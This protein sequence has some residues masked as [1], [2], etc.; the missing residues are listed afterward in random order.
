MKQ[1]FK[2]PLGIE[3]MPEWEKLLQGKLATET[4]HLENSEI[5]IGTL[6]DTIKTQCELLPPRRGHLRDWSPILNN[7][8]GKLDFNQPICQGNHG[9]ALINTFT[10][11]ESES[12]GKGGIIY[13]PGSRV[14]KNKKIKIP[15][16]FWDKNNFIPV[17]EST[18]RFCPFLQTLHKGK[19]MPLVSFHREQMRRLDEFNFGLESDLIYQNFESI[20]PLLIQLLKNAEQS[21]NP[22]RAFQNIISHFIAKDGSM[23][24]FSLEVNPYC[25][26]DDL[27]AAMIL[28]FEASSNPNSFFETFSDLPQ[29]IP[30]MS[31]LLSNLLI[32]QYIPQLSGENYQVH[33]HWESQPLGEDP[34]FQMDYFMDRSSQKHRTELSAIVT[35]Q[36]PEFKP[37][38]FV[39]LPATI[40]LLCP[41]DI[42]SGDSIYLSLL[43]DSIINHP[44]KKPSREEIDL[45]VHSQTDQWYESYKDKLSP[46]FRSRFKTAGVSTVRHSKKPSKSIEP[47][48]FRRLSLR[49]ASMIVGILMERESKEEIS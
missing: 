3:D 11:T 39:S 26:L 49:A 8:S 23:Q 15:L 13:L 44:G 7:A 9:Y 42:E 29:H 5:L 22:Q 16:Y 43:F 38:L 14:S 45:W 25:S 12:E 32:A 1:T 30:L 28:P 2:L 27:A 4:I 41:P 33:F 21:S 10:Q 34:P 18:P 37:T 48:G 36:C 20:K 47:T 6:L 46:Y 31:H 40:F 19:K 24:E 17:T 35:K